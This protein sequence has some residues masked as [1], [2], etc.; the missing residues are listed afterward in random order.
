M[1]QCPAA[2]RFKHSMIP[3]HPECPQC[4]L[5]NSAFAPPS[6]TSKVR[7]P[8]SASASASTSTSVLVVSDDEESTTAARTPLEERAKHQFSKGQHIS[9]NVSAPSKTTVG[10]TSTVNK[11][12]KFILYIHKGTVRSGMDE[13][14][15][16]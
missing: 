5:L 11:P 10:I 6:N 4:G 3:D 9:K 15:I 2:P 1:D 13:F 8:A 16:T 7:T 14:N 12:L